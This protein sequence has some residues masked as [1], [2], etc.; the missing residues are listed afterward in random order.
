MWCFNLKVLLRVCYIVYVNIQYTVCTF[1]VISYIR[2]DNVSGAVRLS[3][4]NIRR[5]EREMKE[6]KG[7]DTIICYYKKIEIGELLR[8]NIFY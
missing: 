7:R 6:K 1:H 8:Y 2:I 5:T 4:C 3:G